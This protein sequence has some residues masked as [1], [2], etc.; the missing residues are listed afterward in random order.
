MMMKMMKIVN[1]LSC[2]KEGT[3]PFFLDDFFSPTKKKK[4]G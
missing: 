2:G 3:S 1:L 4:G